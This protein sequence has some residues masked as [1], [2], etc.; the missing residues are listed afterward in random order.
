MKT[1]SYIAHVRKKRTGSL[2]N[3]YIEEHLR[4]VA[5]L[6]GGFAAHFGNSDWAALAGLWHDFRKSMIAYS[7]F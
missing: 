7:M 5:D 6:A 4:G 2:R 3:I 1:P